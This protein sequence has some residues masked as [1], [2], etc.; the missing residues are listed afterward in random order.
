MRHPKTMKVALWVLL[1]VVIISFVAFYGFSGQP[2]SGGGGLDSYTYVTVETESGEHKLTRSDMAF[3]QQSLATEFAGVYAEMNGMDPRTVSGR[4]LENDLKKREIADYATALVALDDLAEEQGIYVSRVK[5][6]ELLGDSGWTEEILEG[7]ANAAGKT[8]NQFVDGVRETMRRDRARNSISRMARASLLEMWQEYKLQKDQFSLEYVKIPVTKYQ[9]DMEVT[10]EETLAHYEENKEDYSKPE[11]RVYQYLAIDPP[12][13]GEVRVSDE[14]VESAWADLDWESEA[15]EPYKQE[16]GL[17]V[18]QILMRI[19]DEKTTETVRQAMQ[20]LK[21]RI[22]EEEKFEVL[23]NEYTED[24]QNLGF[25]GATSRPQGGLL[26]LRMNDANMERLIA[27]YGESWA[28]MVFGMKEGQISELIESRDMVMI[29]RVEKA[30]EERMTF[31]E[32]K[33]RLRSNIQREGMEAERAKQKA[34]VDENE[35]RLREIVAEQAT[36]EGVA[37]AVDAEVQV[38][39]PVRSVFFNIP[40]VGNLTSS[41]E[42]VAALE[43]GVP[44]RLL[45]TEAAGQFG[46]RLV[47]IE[48]AEVLP[49]R[50]QTLEEARSR[51][52]REVKRNKATQKAKETAERIKVAVEDGATYAEVIEELDLEVKTTEEPF[53]LMQPP[54]DFNI[55]REKFVNMAFDSSA[56]ETLFLESG[57]GTTVMDY[58]VFTVTE[59]NEPDQAEFLTDM[60]DMEREFNRVK[61]SAFVEEWRRDTLRRLKPEYNEDYLAEDDPRVARRRARR[62]T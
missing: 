42:S 60:A 31:D 15:A 11:E 34:A 61:G 44:S 43:Q 55:A 41:R 13:V 8:T 47:V 22:D 26:P 30:Y 50:I 48:V 3:A 10:E 36:L 6:G 56:G 45:R 20:D 37:R 51:A 7:Q 53:A 1:V 52:E 19:T 27:D 35:I 4:P 62:G 16:P 17:E 2:G 46:D 14:D 57:Y 40:G 18:R 24:L 25:D 58:I 12:A 5:V 23:A 29:A 54:P 32:A 21:R 49:E 33:T 38:T 9:P 28:E 39:S 59:R